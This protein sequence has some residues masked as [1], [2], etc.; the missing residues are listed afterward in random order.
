MKRAEEL[1]PGGGHRGVEKPPGWR[2]WWTTLATILAVLLAALFLAVVVR[3]GWVVLA[4]RPLKFPFDPDDRCRQTGYSCGVA[5]SLLMTVLSLAFATAVFVFRRLW[6]IRRSF[7][8]RARDE[9]RDLVQTAGTLI[10][11][12]VGRDELC[13][14]IMDDLKDRRYRR[15]HVVLGGVGVGKTAVLVE[16]TK[17]LAEH[18]AVPVPVRLRDAQEQ[19]DF[20]GMARQ[21]FITEVGR[22][23]YSDAEADRVWRE[24]RRR[25]QIVVLADGLEEALSERGDSAGGTGP[26]SGADSGDR[27]NRIRVAIRSAQRGRL[28]LVVAS[29]PHDA[30][31]GLDAAVVELEPLGEE[32]ALEYIQEG[33]ST[34]AE[35][36]LDWIIETA[37]VTE[38]P[39]YLQLAHELYGK[40]LLERA[41][42]GHDDDQLD[43]RGND[44]V[45]LRLRL[46]E[47]WTRGLIQGHFHADIP[48][49]KELRRA[50]IQQL[51]V[52]ACVGLMNDT[53][54]VKL[55]DRPNASTAKGRGLQQA[56]RAAIE[57]L[58]ASIQFDV[59][60]DSDGERWDGATERE[61]RLAVTR[62]VRLGLVEARGGGVRFPH[63]IM[64]AYLGSRVIAHALDEVD[65]DGNILHIDK[66]DDKV[67][68]K[69]DDD[70]KAIEGG[71]GSKGGKGGKGGKGSKAGKAGKAAKAEDDIPYLKAALEHSSREL[72]AALVMRSRTPR[73][74]RGTL[75]PPSRVQAP[76][77]YADPN[78][79]RGQLFNSAGDPGRPPGNAIDLMVAALEIDSVAESPR[80]QKLAGIL[81]DRWPDQ[82]EDRTVEDAKLKAVVRLGEVIRN[83]GDRA[84][85]QAAPDLE[86]AYRALYRIACKDVWY[87]VRLAAAQEIGRG[88]DQAVIQL[89]SE[90]EKDDPSTKVGNTW[91]ED[92]KH[93]E[94]VLRAWLAPLLVSSASDDQQLCARANLE[95]WLLYMGAHE[96]GGGSTAP[97]SLEIALAQG[98]KHAA[99]RRPGRSQGA[100]AAPHNLAEKAAKMLASAR[101]W[102]SRLTLVQVLCLWALSDSE[103]ARERREDSQGSRMRRRREP[104][105]RG[106]DPAALIS[107]WLSSAGGGREHPF[108]DEACKLGALALE[109]RQP[110]RY[111]W[112]DESGVVTKIGSRPPRPDARRKHNLWIPPSAGWSALHP[113]AQR[114]VADVLILLNLTER[115][116][117][118]PED[119]EE[120][121][122]KAMRDDL[123]ACLAGERSYLEV[124]RTVGTAGVPTPGASCKHGCEFDLCP[125]PPKGTA[126]TYRVELSESFC[127]R[128]QILLRRRSNGL[129]RRTARWQGALPPELRQFWR[130]MEERARR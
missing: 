34:H 24:L 63:S 119:R 44:R 54:Q 130:L 69:V 64:Q 46:L 117:D 124:N 108:V 28:P 40:G 30:L 41:R 123:P 78:D 128:Q 92:D 72:L 52:L 102:Y 68:D 67:E 111:I 100:K 129:G 25:D 109:W 126:Q 42:P 20:A 127:R 73:D 86:P 8:R 95:K 106:S 47:T 59:P 32:H 31:V 48:M 53:L 74:K 76:D 121:L 26:D 3:A 112:I 103:M 9:S 33:A 23:A 83:I 85:E 66:V 36:R 75:I 14:V 15:P 29:R 81:A 113:R 82:S 115:G 101:F 98:F 37:D 39:L 12:V 18:G 77:Y 110:E 80:H 27:D 35:Q 91:K 55:A 51:G 50:T 45:G 89:C 65:K 38:T 120:R 105:R 107:H 96:G 71:K 4:G 10:G 93:R 17:R 122:R 16:L 62:G 57:D 97:L 7:A 99:N 60:A 84:E 49:S 90:W 21:R 87:P 125:Y 118:L 2:R 116:T 114:L 6:R 11:S 56:L 43:T 88:A 5:S 104:Q 22:T 13:N 70:G 1:L 79:V 61:L 58:Y 94:L 19:L